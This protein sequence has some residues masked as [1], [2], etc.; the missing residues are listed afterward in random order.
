MNEGSGVWLKNIV[1]LRKSRNISQAQMARTLN[2]A[3]QLMSLYE[4]G[5]NK[6]PL[7]HLIAICRAYQVSP[8]ELLGLQQIDDSW[9]NNTEGLRLGK[10][11]SD[12]IYQLRKYRGMSQAELGRLLGL[13]TMTVLCYEQGKHKLPIPVFCA[14][15]E[16][17]GVRPVSFLGMTDEFSSQ[18]A[19]TERYQRKHQKRCVYYN[20]EA[21]CCQKTE[22]D[23]VGSHFCDCYREEGWPEK[24]Y[25]KVPSPPVRRVVKKEQR[26]L[27]VEV[28]VGGF[29]I[30][31][32]TRYLVRAV[33]TDENGETRYACQRVFT[34]KT[35]EDKESNPRWICQNYFLGD[36]KTHWFTRDQISSA[37]PIPPEEWQAFMDRSA[38]TP[39]NQSEAAEQSV[40]SRTGQTVWRT[41]RAER[42]EREGLDRKAYKIV[43]YEGRLHWAPGSKPYAYMYILSKQGTKIF[44]N[45]DK[46]NMIIY[47]ARKLYN[48]YIS[49]FRDASGIRLCPAEKNQ[50]G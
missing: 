40:S 29:A 18:G 41:D 42:K 7:S 3:P 9:L 37:E 6:L 11:V 10:S 31:D 17:F 47:V 15:C 44:V 34:Y 48:K 45:V 27:N 20:K 46:R 8:D 21:G 32:S 22:G 16:L 2:I 13:S 39:R 33:E 49:V 26:S 5:V 43:P 38:A 4:R 36:L 30:I 23:C 24:P 19:K 14:M 28:A 1:T 12:N 25:A 50:N 35:V